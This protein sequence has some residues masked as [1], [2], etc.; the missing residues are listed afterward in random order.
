MEAKVYAVYLKE[1]ESVLQQVGNI[2]GRINLTVQSW[3]PCQT[4]G[5]I[6]LAGKFIDSEW[7][8]HRRMLNLVMVPW[9]GS[10]HAVTEA[11]PCDGLLVLFISRS[12]PWPPPLSTWIWFHLSANGVLGCSV[13]KL[14]LPIFCCVSCWES[15][16][17]SAYVQN[18]CQELIYL[19]SYTRGHV[20]VLSV[21]S[22]GKGFK[23]R[24]LHEDESRNTVLLVFASKPDLPNAWSAFTLSA[25]LEH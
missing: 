23:F 15:V 5:Y 1:R 10:E 17:C 12:L 3:A 14:R 21:L 16:H 9:S 20:T 11:K 18:F 19:G 2:P 24:M 25:S 6:S 22:R 8:L 4:R 7:K 13:S